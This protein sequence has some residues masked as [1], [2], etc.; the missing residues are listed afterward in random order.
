MRLRY[1]L[2]P[3]L[4]HQG[5]GLVHYD[6]VAGLLMTTLEE[7]DVAGH[8]IDEVADK[9]ME[10]RPQKFDPERFKYVSLSRS[11]HGLVLQV[12][13]F[14]GTIKGG[15]IKGG[16]ETGRGGWNTAA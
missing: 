10:L 14:S 3:S 13:H 1:I 16:M 11:M 7:M 4:I 2:T 5:L 6:R 12:L 8:I 9:V 15:T